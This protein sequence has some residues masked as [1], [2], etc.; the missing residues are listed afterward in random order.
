MDSQQRQ[1]LDAVTAELSDSA[2]DTTVDADGYELILLQEPA[3][4]L[5]RR[6]SKVHDPID[7]I[8][9]PDL[10]IEGGVDKGI[11]RLSYVDEGQEVRMS[12]QQV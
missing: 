3:N 9:S 11:R 7:V 8:Q 6:Q 2:S 4:Q 12:L 1:K 5:L 10:I